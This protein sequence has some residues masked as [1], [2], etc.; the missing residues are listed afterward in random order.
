[1]S[2][3]DRKY[4]KT[5][6]AKRSLRLRHLI[7]GLLIL[8]TLLFGAIRLTSLSPYTTHS[9]S[10]QYFRAKVLNVHETQN[11]QGAS[12]NIKVRILD[13]SDKGQTVSVSRGANFGDTSYNRIPVGSEVL[14]TKDYNNGNQYSFGDRWRIPGAVTLFLLLLVLVVV[15]GWWRGLTS[16]LGLV[17]SIGVLSVYTVPSILAGHSAYATCLVTAFIITLISIYLAHGFS[18]RTTIA[19]IGS[20]TT[21]LIVI[22]LV[23]LA[24]YL[25]GTSEVIN[26][27]T[28]GALYNGTHAISLSGLLTGG[29]IIA[30]LGVLYDITTGQSASVDEIYKANTKLTPLQLYRRG[31]SVGREHIAALVNTLALVYVGIALPSILIA[32]IYNNHAPLIIAINNEAVIEEVVRTFVA[33]VGMLLAVPITTGLAVYILPKWYSSDSKQLLSRLKAIINY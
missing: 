11:A 6:F 9:G 20:L 3:Y 31:L 10:L 29:I 19:L 15:V 14:L 25:A 33:S 24:T 4:F 16:I 32:A 7:Y 21:L 18:K 5:L 12:Q 30:S 1:M 2:E 28:A 8:L 26:E 13:G 27:D 23:A 17:I 22:G